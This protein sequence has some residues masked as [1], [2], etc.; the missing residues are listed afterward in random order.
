MARASCCLG[1]GSGADGPRA[2]WGHPPHGTGL[3][4]TLRED[5]S[6]YDVASDLYDGTASL[7]TDGAGDVTL[8]G[9]MFHVNMD[10]DG[11]LE[12]ARFAAPI[13]SPL[14]FANVK[15]MAGAP[16]TRGLGGAVDR[17]LL[18]DASLTRTG[19]WRVTGDDRARLACEACTGGARDLLVD[20]GEFDGR[21]LGRGDEAGEQ[22][23][24]TWPIGTDLAGG[25]GAQRVADRADPITPLVLEYR[26]PVG[27]AHR[28]V[29]REP[30]MVRAGYVDIPNKPGWGVEL[31]EEAFEHCPAYLGSAPLVTARTAR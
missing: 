17:I 28:D 19:S 7:C 2:N 12:G 22:V 4:A 1:R 11:N 20:G 6:G 15:G 24:G 31:N 14:L 10:E 25:F 9:A 29:L 27:G 18:P 23:I 13:E 3:T 8:G 21:L 5:G 26:A 16:W 30:L